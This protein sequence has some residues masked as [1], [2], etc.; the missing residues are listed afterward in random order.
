MRSKMDRRTFLKAAGGAVLAA[1][2]AGCGGTSTAGNE[3]T[4]QDVVD[5]IN[6]AMKSLGRDLRGVETDEM[7]HTAEI[8]LETAQTRYE[9]DQSKS[10]LELLTSKEAIQAAQIDTQKE[11]YHIN[12]STNPGS[13]GITSMEEQKKYITDSFS[14]NRKIIGEDRVNKKDTVN[15]G[16]AFGK[17]GQTEYIILL[18]RVYSE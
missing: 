18:Q 4:K 10:V 11:T 12:L 7:D 2:L 16:I 15:V 5:I 17:I 1:V 9:S 13:I 14:R 3:L 8:L 6:D